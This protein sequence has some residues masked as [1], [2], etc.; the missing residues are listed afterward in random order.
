MPGFNGFQ[1]SSK[2]FTGIPDQFFSEIMPILHDANAIKIAL[3]VLWSAY[4][5]GDFG[6]VFTVDDF[7]NDKILISSLH[8]DKS[9]SE[10]IIT[11]NLKIL[12]S[13]NIL[14]EISTTEGSGQPVYF[15]NS[16]RGRQAASYNS[17]HPLP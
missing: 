7:L 9:D 5:N 12:T 11:S 17:W 2:R 13:E 15:I 6:L 14:I 4:R 3:Y 8:A 1:E 16:P 10:N